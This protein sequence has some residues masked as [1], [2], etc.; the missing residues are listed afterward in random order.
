MSWSV[1]TC[2]SFNIIKIENQQIAYNH[3]LPIKLSPKGI[4]FLL[5]CILCV[6]MFVVTLM[7]YEKTSIM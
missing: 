2:N 4:Q 7:N 1:E 5:G 6:L 3:K